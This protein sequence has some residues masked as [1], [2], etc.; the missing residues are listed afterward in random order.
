DGDGFDTLIEE[1][2]EVGKLGA[3]ERL[4]HRMRLGAVRVGNADEIDAG[5][6]G[7]HAGMIAAHHADAN[8]P[9]TQPAAGAHNGGLHVNPPVRFTPALPSTAAAPRRPRRPAP[10]T[11]IESRDY[12][13][14]RQRTDYRGEISVACSIRPPLSV[15]RSPLAAV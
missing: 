4:A 12:M 13:A 10:R 2:R 8:D 11:Q 7:K 1:R 3:A 15:V 6:L 14:R 5:K 9:D